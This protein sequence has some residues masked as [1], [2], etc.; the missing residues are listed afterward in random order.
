MLKSCLAVSEMNYPYAVGN[1]KAVE[2]RLFDKSKFAKLAR[3]EKSDFLKT[4]KELGY[5]PSVTS[6]NL[7][8]LIN[9]ELA[10]LKEYF[11]EISPDPKLTDLFFMANDATN[12]KIMFKQRL[13]ATEA[14]HR[15]SHNGSINPNS[16]EKAIISQDY[17]EVAP[18]VKALLLD[19]EQ[20]ILPL[21]SARII[22]SK[23]DNA[24]YDYIFKHMGFSQARVLRKY[25]Q[26]LIDTTNV[27]SW[28]RCRLLE[29]E[30][31]EFATMFIKHG[32][33]PLDVFIQSYAMNKDQV[34]RVFMDFY[35]EKITKALKAYFERPHLNQIEK[36]LDLLVLELMQEEKNESFTIGPMIYYY[37]QKV[38][39]A[40]NIRLLYSSVYFDP[41][42]LL[43][44]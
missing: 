18:E 6:D 24:V 44:Y 36:Q 7:E 39:E 21:S 34:L 31:S 20:Q 30:L 10:A 28:L 42:D 38:A 8:D 32:L 14:L 37:L 16:L 5:A 4:L 40:K 27:I 26:A 35:Q 3:V 13:F 29:W 2:S 17:S 23:I 15:Y 19:I 43:E 25:Y 22:S 12:I 33:I 9:D 11:A 41:N 1:I